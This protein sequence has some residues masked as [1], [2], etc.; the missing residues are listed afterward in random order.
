MHWRPPP[1]WIRTGSSG[2]TAGADRY[3]AAL[4]RIDGRVDV[5][6]A[7]L[8]LTFSPPK[9]VSVLYAF[10]DRP[11]AGQVRAAHHAAVEQ[12]LAYL[13]TTCAQAMRGHH[14]GAAQTRTVPTDG[15]IGCAFEHRT[16][17]DGDPQLHT[18]V[19]TVN[20]AHGA[21]GR[22]SAADTRALY[23]QA[24]TA[25]YV[26]QAVLRGELTRRL[27]VGWT[28]VRKG[29]AEIDGIPT[30]VLAEFSRRRRQITA[31]LER[32]GRADPAAA[33]VAAL[34]TRP[35]KTTAPDAD[36]R[37]EWSVRARAAGFD[38]DRVAAVLHR[39]SAPQIPPVRLLAG[40]LLAASGLTRRR[41]T[42]DRR[43]LLK[44]VCEALP[45]GAA[46]DTAELRRLA[47]DLVRH[48]QV[49][50]LI[51]D[52]PAAARRYS[53]R[54][55]LAT[56]QAALHAAAGRREDGLAVVDPAT[57]DRALTGSRLSAEQE[58]M[59]RALTGSGA[60]VEVV[61]GP[62]GSGKTAALAAA[63]AAWE[64][65]GHPVLGA[66][67][68]AIAA[69]TLA[70]G[71]GI[72]SSSL[73]RLLAD[74]RRVD[75]VTGRPAGLPAG[76]V[77]VVDEAGMVDTRTLAA[78]IGLTAAA[79][80][81]LVLVGDPRQLPE[82]DAGGLFA[83]LARDLPAV[84][85]AGNQRQPARWEQE[86]LAGLRDGDVL[87]A[88]DTY[89]AHDRLRLADDVDGLRERIVADFLAARASRGPGRALMLTSRRTD[90]AALSALTRQR[91]I[92]DGALG[93]VELTVRVA[94]RE[95][96]FRTGED[97]VV[98]VNDYRRG[99]FNGT[100]GRIVGVDPA[101]R[102]VELGLDDGRTVPL[103][104]GALAAGWLTHGYALTCHK[105]Q[106]ITVDVALLYGTR[107]LCREAG[108]VGLSR[109]RVGNYLYATWDNLAPDTGV[110]VDRPRTDQPAIDDPDEL[111]RAALVERLETSSAQR[112]ALEQRRRWWPPRDR[113]RPAP[114][115]RRE[116]PPGRAAGR[117]R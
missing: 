60:G 88:V 99:L 27:G 8:D 5:R 92:A 9:S 40:R 19:V 116:P 113:S 93:P 4:A 43:D 106:G 115:L 49:V 104:A 20:L 34:A 69:R 26:Y 78:L 24:Q 29:A 117:E 45:A 73:T 39:V 41:S 87:T 98:T 31:E 23:H 75:P 56:E 108:Y 107:T 79:R 18:H 64:R 68:A 3:A 51:P 48:A 110:D 71:A 67:V 22:W 57:I 89:A 10:A 100:R 36:M 7:G 55:L 72:S 66:A 102:G 59:V 15:L 91:L 94:G 85:L 12:A 96:G 14:G 42:F 62:A 28:T 76:S 2:T 32:R 21:D 101:G 44:G 35:A 65:A 82:I 30:G 13:E 111:A 74:A 38:P 86:A 90:A 81:K 77:L 80:V 84:R 11:T 6:R 112:L 63:R 95:L 1:V 53:T 83:A 37:H 16:S 109:G 50:P 47:T 105:A 17:R 70:D 54:E 33:Q 114:L 61:V 103:P 46:V 58:A 52:A 97:V 25:G